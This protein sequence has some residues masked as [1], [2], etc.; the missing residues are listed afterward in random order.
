MAP[1]SGTAVSRRPHVVSPGLTNDK[2]KT[3]KLTETE[4][5]GSHDRRDD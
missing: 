2:V 5:P 1:L 3:P 4:R